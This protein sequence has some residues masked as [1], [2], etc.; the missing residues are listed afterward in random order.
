MKL[1]KFKTSSNISYNHT[2]KNLIGAPYKKNIPDNEGIKAFQIIL[3]R[4]NIMIKIIITLLH[5]VL[6]LNGFIFNCQNYL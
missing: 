1:Q 6:T 2:S 4:K 3:K 5:L